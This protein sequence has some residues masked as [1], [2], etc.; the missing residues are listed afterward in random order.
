VVHS[1]VETFSEV[2]LRARWVIFWGVLWRALIIQLCVG[3]SDQ[4]AAWSLRFLVQWLGSLSGMSEGGVSTL[5]AAVTGTAYLVLWAGGFW[6][7]VEWLF[8]ARFEG[9][10]YLKLVR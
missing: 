8:L 4:V 2:S 10:Y 5:N 3:A 9:G 6:V 1:E 7:L